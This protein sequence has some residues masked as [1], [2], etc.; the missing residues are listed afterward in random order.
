MIVCSPGATRAQIR[1]TSPCKQL[2]R[3]RRER[4]ADKGRHVELKRRLA[5]TSL[6]QLKWHF[7]WPVGV[8]HANL[9]IMDRGTE[10]NGR[11]D[12]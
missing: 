5:G 8:Y 2:Q 10:G 11:S 3:Q 9:A 4:G 6:R 7:H 1:Y 12:E